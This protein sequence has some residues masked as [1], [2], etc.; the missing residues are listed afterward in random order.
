MFGKSKEREF[1]MTVFFKR[2]AG[3]VVFW[4]IV[5]KTGHKVG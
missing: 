5:E 1:P 4:T 3:K 2:V